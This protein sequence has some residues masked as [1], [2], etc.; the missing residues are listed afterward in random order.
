MPT[1]YIDHQNKTVIMRLNEQYPVP[2]NAHEVYNQA[3]ERA[4]VILNEVMTADRERRG[5]IPL[6]N[7]R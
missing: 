2:E 6:R 4:R 3:S 5:Y 7:R 1:P